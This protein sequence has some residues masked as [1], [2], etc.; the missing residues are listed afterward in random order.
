MSVKNVITDIGKKIKNFAESIVEQALDHV[1]HE[2]YF[3]YFS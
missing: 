1:Y 3:S 2:F